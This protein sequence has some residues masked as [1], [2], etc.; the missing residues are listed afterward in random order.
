M[1]QLST[2]KHKI[3]KKPTKLK[4]FPLNQRSCSPNTFY[5]HK[6]CHSAG[7][8]F[9][10]GREGKR[11]QGGDLALVGKRKK[12]FLHGGC[13]VVF[14]FTQQ[15]TGQSACWR[16]KHLTQVQPICLPLAGSLSGGGWG[17][18]S[19]SRLSSAESFPLQPLVTV[20]PPRL[21]TPYAGWL[22][23]LALCNPLWG[24]KKPQNK[25]VNFKSLNSN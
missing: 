2:W 14:L 9:L 11:E 20:P 5:L 18:L 25:Q 16:D 4:I 17:Q 3:E 10:W 22:T 7:L 6:R 21:L 15:F 13:F 23:A 24:K 8:F 19:S 12:V 1:F